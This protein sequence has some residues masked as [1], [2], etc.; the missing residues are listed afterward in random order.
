MREQQ[1]FLA[2]SICPEHLGV[3]GVAR[4]RASREW[5][6]RVN[7]VILVHL[8]CG[9]AVLMYV[10]GDEFRDA[11]L[12]SNLWCEELLHNWMVD[13]SRGNERSSTEITGAGHNF[14][15]SRLDIGISNMKPRFRACVPARRSSGEPE[16]PARPVC[17]RVCSRCTRAIVQLLSA[18]RWR[19][20][21]LAAR[22]QANETIPSRRANC[23]Q[24]CPSWL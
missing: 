3:D 8:V 22:L 2:T 21:Y 18:S 10:E 1:R 16:G 7:E 4:F 6:Q 15:H 12:T 23:R 14:L 11:I 5:H 19:V 13:V 24:V 17:R 20:P 9:V